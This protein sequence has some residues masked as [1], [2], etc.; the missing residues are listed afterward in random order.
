V[1]IYRFHGN[2]REYTICIIDLGGDG[3]RWMP[4]SGQYKAPLAVVTIQ[5]SHST[6]KSTT[7]ITICHH[8]PVVDHVV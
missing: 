2:S 1:E 8:T 6:T 3:V 5:T 7:K 4:L